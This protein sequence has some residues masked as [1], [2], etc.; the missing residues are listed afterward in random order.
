MSAIVQRNTTE[1]A[2]EELHFR[3]TKMDSKRMAPQM[4]KRQLKSQET[5]RLLL[6]AAEEVFFRDGYEKAELGEIA[7]M[8][9][10]TKGAIYAQFKSKEDIFLALYEDNALQRRALML[11]YLAESDSMDGNLSAFRRY[12]LEFATND[13]WAFL[14][15]DFRLYAMRNPKS[16]KRLLKL[17]KS[18]LPANEEGTYSNLLGP[19]AKGSGS[20]SRTEAV[21]TSF[22]M[23]TSL[24]LEA[25]F[26]PEIVTPEVLL[27]VAARI[28][29]SIFDS[30]TSKV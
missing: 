27:K 10:R 26:N 30:A 9:G 15:L 28:F 25:K 11:E 2:S 6:R 3:S 19:V 16:R 12:F 4:T 21:H 29:D 18:V 23:L 20:I 13:R 1:P 22:A 7:R 24:Q 17:F 5:R 8:V 14:L